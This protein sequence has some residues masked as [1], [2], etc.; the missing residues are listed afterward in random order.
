MI[1][2]VWVWSKKRE[3]QMMSKQQI[4]KAITSML[5]EATNVNVYYHE[6]PL[7]T[8]YPYAVFNI[9]ERYLTEGLYSNT[10]SVDVYALDIKTLDDLEDRLKMLNDRTYSENDLT[11]DIELNTV[12]TLK[13]ESIYHLNMLFYLNNFWEG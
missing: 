1:A 12:N 6:V 11:F 13:N 4:K 7:N 5:K 3:V 10:L 8:E 9:R 2:L